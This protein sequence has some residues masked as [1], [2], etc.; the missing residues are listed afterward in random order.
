MSEKRKFPRERCKIS[1]KFK[2]YEGNP[3][4]IDM[5]TTTPVKGKGVMLDISRGGTFVVS[6]SR[7]SINIPIR[8]SFKAMKKKYN[9]DGQI[10]RTGLL[11]NNPSEIV[12]R[13]ADIKVKGD[14]YI[15]VQF[16]N[17][18]DEMII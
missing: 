5:G 6:N 15:A 9:I 13:F 11:Q 4:E 16:N 1:V 10:V 2:Y 18:I 14:T 8:L 3:D 7:V 12:Q 17:P